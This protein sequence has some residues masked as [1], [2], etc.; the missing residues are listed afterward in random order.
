M[1]SVTCANL[2]GA[3]RATWLRSS[4]PARAST[5]PTGYLLTCPPARAVCVP[6]GAACP[7]A[8]AAYPH[9]HPRPY[10]ALR[11]TLHTWVGVKCAEWARTLLGR[12]FWGRVCILPSRHSSMLPSDLQHCQPCMKLLACGRTGTAPRLHTPPS[13]I[14]ASTPPH[15]RFHPPHIR[16]EAHFAYLGGRE[17]CRVGPNAVGSVVLGPS[18]HSWVGFMCAMW[19]RTR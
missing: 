11:P 12:W 6:A 1:A 2:K 19:A 13:R 14:R 5:P 9:I 17:V 8:R 15:P 7:P 4:G 18:L 16:V 3:S 10:S